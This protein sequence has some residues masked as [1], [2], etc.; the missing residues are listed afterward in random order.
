M[1]KQIISELSK[2]TCQFIPN[3]PILKGFFHIHKLK[4]ALDNAMTQVVIEVFH[5]GD[6]VLLDKVLREK[7]SHIRQS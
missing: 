1:F 5:I 2:L 6:Y 4:V 3:C 7:L